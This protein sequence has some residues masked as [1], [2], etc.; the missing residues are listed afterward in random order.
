[1]ASGS[2]SSCVAVALHDDVE[3]FC[4]GD[5]FRADRILEEA[6]SRQYGAQKTAW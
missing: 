1:M 4:S 2:D 3:R 5:I 6:M